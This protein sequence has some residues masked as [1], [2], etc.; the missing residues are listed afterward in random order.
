MLFLLKLPT[1]ASTDPEQLGLGVERPD[2]GADD[3]GAAAQSEHVADEGLALPLAD[4]HVGDLD[5]G[6][7]VRL[8]EHA[9]SERALC[10]VCK[11]GRKDRRVVWPHEIRLVFAGFRQVFFLCV[12]GKQWTHTYI[13]T[14]TSHLR[15]HSCSERAQCV[16]GDGR[17]VVL[18]DHMKYKWSLLGSDNCPV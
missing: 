6:V 13:H 5:H 16:R 8:R 18:S 12:V 11:R 7:L 9:C 4:H 1:T 2:V 10:S 15:E 14:H 3:G 17:P